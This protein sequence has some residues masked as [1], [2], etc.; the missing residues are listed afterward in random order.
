MTF[1]PDTDLS[2]SD[3]SSVSLENSWPAWGRIHNEMVKMLP[4][5]D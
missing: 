4:H 1:S 3:G 5:H 2:K